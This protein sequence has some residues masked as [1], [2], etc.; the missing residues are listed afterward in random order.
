MTDPLDLTFTALAD[1]RRRQMLT[2]LS[3]GP[4]SVKDIAR[5]LQIALP[6]AVK[7][8]AILE[9]ARLVRSHKSGRTRTFELTP[10]AFTGIEDWVADRKAALNRQFDALD[11]YLKDTAPQ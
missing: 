8:L 2:H 4:Q 5:P 1:A 9:N 6:S 7:H 10:D 11:R 3:T